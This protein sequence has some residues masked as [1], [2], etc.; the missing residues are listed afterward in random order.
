MD[1]AFPT[2]IVLASTFNKDL[3]TR[4]GELMAEECLY[5]GMM[6]N[7]MPG[8]NLHRTPFGGRNFEYYS[9]DAVMNYLCEI[10]EV[11][12]MEKKGRSCRCEACHRK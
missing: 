11:Q 10:P 6:E 5:L 3:M 12:A 1:C 7:W 8:V 9:E 4:R 2:E